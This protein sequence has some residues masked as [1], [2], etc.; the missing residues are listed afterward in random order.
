MQ[1]TSV[2]HKRDPEHY[3]EELNV[4]LQRLT[5]N[6]NPKVVG[7]TAYALHKYPSDVDVFEQVKTNLNRKNALKFY[8]DHFS[9]VGK[10]IAI[11]SEDMI[12][13]DFKAGQDLRF[14]YKAFKKRNSSSFGWKYYLS[15]L[16]KDRLL[17]LEEE[18]DLANEI[19]N[20]QSDQVLETLEKLLRDK[21][22][23]RWTVSEMIEKKKTLLRGKSIT[24]EDA[25]SQPYIVKLDVFS[26]YS[27]RYQSVEVFYTLGYK[28]GT[29]RRNDG[30]FNPMGSY[31]QGLLEDIEK[32]S[33]V[34]P[35]KV[36]KRMWSLARV[37][38]CEDMLEALTPELGSDAAA[39]NQVAG[40]L[41][42]LWTLLDKGLSAVHIKNLFIELIGFGKRTAPHI[43]PN[44]YAEFAEIAEP[45]FGIWTQWRTTGE[46][47][48]EEL[49]ESMIKGYELL[50]D[51]ISIQAG[52]FLKKVD[53]LNITCNNP[54]FSEI[55]KS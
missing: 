6:E 49:I 27:G 55:I 23:V 3:P 13:A 12:F 42:M 43:S 14:S 11:D 53:E 7:S 41:E 51:V 52:S 34:S 21:R 32:Y 45:W 28:K 40:D 17:T 36:I 44:K 33:D 9:R 10:I 26:W 39:L 24:L 47:R 22:V 54:R 25:L 15:K 8:A 31:T 30:S 37:T 46:L 5:I 18:S 29:G 1:A 4:I 19:E 50:Q 38:D 16:L 2:L 48:R 20:V 35:L